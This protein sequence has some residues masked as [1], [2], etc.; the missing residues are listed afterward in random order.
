MLQRITAGRSRPLILLLVGIM[1]V[2]G[3][4][5]ATSHAD[6]DLTIGG[7]AVVAYANGDSVRLRSEP[8]TGAGVIDRIAEGTQVEVLDGPTGGSGMLWYLVRA[9]GS[10]GYMAADF[11]A[12]SA[13]LLRATSGNA[14]ANSSV[15]VRSGPS[16]A[17]SVVTTLGYGESVTLTGSS[18]N[19]WLSVS[20]GG[21]SGWVYGAFL[22]QDAG[23]ASSGTSSGTSYGAT[24]TYYTS[25]NLNLRAGPTTREGVIDTLPRG[26][27]VWLYGEEENGFAYAS[28]DSGDG[29]LNV[30]YL[31]TSQPTSSASQAVAR[32]APTSVGQQMAN[33]ALQYVGLPYVWAGAGPGGFDCSGLTMYVAANVLGLDITHSTVIQYGYGSAVGYGDWAPGDLVFF[34][35]T[36]TAGIS[37]VGI[38]IGDGQF[39]HAE[40]PG[41]GVV[42]SSMYDS[43]YSAHYAGARRLA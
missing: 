30:A 15:N 19:G 25:D 8:N 41:T 21:G 5:P 38:Y 12:S 7:V 28:T 42:I 31:S 40:N 6:T 3:L 18:S 43:Y 33:F 24:G 1:I 37:H 16:T 11:L 26:A 39:V 27:E 23:Y 36:Y 10:K 17:D 32:S 14:F 34:A 20:A 2:S 29:W 35:N 4:F 9:N 13:G 22:S